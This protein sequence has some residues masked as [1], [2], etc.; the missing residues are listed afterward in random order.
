LLPPKEY[1]LAQKKKTR[2]PLWLIAIVI[3]Y[4]L[5]KVANQSFTSQNDLD[6]FK[7]N[8]L[9][10]ESALTYEKYESLFD[11]YKTT[12]LS[13][14]AFS[15]AQIECFKLG[16]KFWER[17]P[18]AEHQD[19]KQFFLKVGSGEDAIVLELRLF[20]N[21]VY[22]S[23]NKKIEHGFKGGFSAVSKCAENSDFYKI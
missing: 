5:V 20:K 3:I 10:S 21:K 14:G 9:G 17:M 1:E 11:S 12:P 4:W 22:F 6:T 2:I 8:Y 15:Q 23:V 13:R 7:V 16:E 19:T 18:S